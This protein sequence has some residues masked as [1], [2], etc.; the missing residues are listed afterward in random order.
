MSGTSSRTK[1][2]VLALVLAAL[3][4]A[5]LVGACATNPATGK[6]MFSLVSEEEEAQMGLQAHPGILAEYGVYDDEE[7]SA[8]VQNLG[9]KMALRSELPDLDW[10]FTVLDSPVVNA[11]ALPGGYIYITRGLMAHADSEAQ[12]AGVIGH[13]IGH[14]TARHS[15][16]QMSRQQALGLGVGL[17]AV[18]SPEFARFGQLAQQGLGLMLLKYGRSQEEQA[19][20]L[21]IRYALRSGY[22]PRKLSGFFEVLDRQQSRAGADTLPAWL[23]THPA[24]ENRVEDTSRIAK[25][26][27]KESGRKRDLKVARAEYLARIDGM[28]FGDDP[29]Q[30]YTEGRDFYHPGM[31]F[32]LAFPKGW[33]VL[34]TPTAV[35]SA[36]SREQTTA[37]LRMT[38]GQP[39]AG[40]G[41]EDYLRRH[42]AKSEGMRLGEG[43]TETVNGLPAFTAT[44]RFSDGQGGERNAFVGAV[45]YEGAMYEFVG[46]TTAESFGSH[47]PAFAET[48]RSFAELTDRSKLEVKPLRVEIRSAPRTETFGEYL[49]SLGDLPVEPQEMA[50]LNQ[51]RR[52]DTVEQG[53]LIKVL[54]R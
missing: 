27:V 24:P 51:T 4:M 54:V 41:P 15:A 45:L 28:V 42:A 29:R 22:D 21:G 35:L 49:D 34:N 40:E 10:T 53:D 17:G 19:D 1:I 48:V 2:R 7:L 33:L 6:K 12:L 13:E 43:R 18:L 30:G 47:R 50:I 38:L 3:L 39:R 5:G 44:A 23:S 16:Q 25:E 46:Q 11:F 9:R 8:W 37:V 26:K 31:R 20:E 52:K 36:D 32:R 14:V